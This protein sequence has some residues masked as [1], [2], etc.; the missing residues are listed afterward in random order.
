AEFYG[1]FR[2][3][4]APLIMA[5]IAMY[6]GPL[7]CR[8]Q[9]PQ[10]ATTRDGRRSGRAVAVCETAQHAYPTHSPDAH[11]RAGLVVFLEPPVSRRRSRPVRWTNPSPEIARGADRRPA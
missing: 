4:S 3:D 10:A 1:A 5:W 2:L 11:C 8:S 7:I 9:L 6:S